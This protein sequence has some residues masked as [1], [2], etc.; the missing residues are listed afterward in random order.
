MAFNS[1]F[2]SHFRKVWRLILSNG[3]QVLIQIGQRTLNGRFAK[4]SG[5]R[6]II[7]FSGYLWSGQVVSV[8][9]QSRA[10]KRFSSRYFL[11]CWCLTI[12]NAPA[13]RPCLLS[14]WLWVHFKYLFPYSTDSCLR[15]TIWFH[16]K[17]IH[18]NCLRINKHHQRLNQSNCIWSL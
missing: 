4:L 17:D 12:W 9:E 16:I 3:N 15:H 14:T 6:P 8:S 2:L 10:K 1:Y 18:P 13:N 7:I 5:T 11:A